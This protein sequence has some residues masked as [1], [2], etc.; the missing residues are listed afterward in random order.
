MASCPYRVQ[1]V[2]TGTVQLRRKRAGT[3]VKLKTEIMV[4]ISL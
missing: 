4:N 2:E 3:D 1:G